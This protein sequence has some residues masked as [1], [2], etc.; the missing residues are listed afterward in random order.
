MGNNPVH[1]S[2]RFKI[3]AL[4]LVGFA[5]YSSLQAFIK[6]DI[7]DFIERY[8]RYGEI[9]SDKISQFEAGLSCARSVLSPDEQVGFISNYEGADWSQVYLWTQYTLA[10]VIVLPSQDAEKLVA[11]YSGSDRLGQVKD[12]GFTILVN[13]KNG[14]G[15]VAREGTP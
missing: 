13:C 2:W 12:A 15:L 11:V 9:A 8:R 14:I 7:R 10:P 6:Y 3:G 4:L 5:L 1:L